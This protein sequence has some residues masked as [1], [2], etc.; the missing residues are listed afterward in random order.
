ME[1]KIRTVDSRHDAFI[2][3]DDRIIIL[4]GFSTDEA[5][6]W[7]ETAVTAQIEKMRTGESTA[8][9]T[10]LVENPSDPNPRSIERLGDFGASIVSDA[11]ST[12]AR[13]NNPLLQ[14]RKAEEFGLP[15][16]PGREQASAYW[17]SSPAGPASN[18]DLRQILE[19]AQPKGVRQLSEI[20]AA[21]GS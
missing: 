19:W 18:S 12:I 10:I 3:A 13:L 9:P 14:P 4:R 5:Q 15:A 21:V 17:A 7:V 16:R 11:A 1:R 6:G 8:L 20:E 2:E